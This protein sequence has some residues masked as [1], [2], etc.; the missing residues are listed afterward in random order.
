MKWTHQLS[1]N[2]KGPQ[3]PLKIPN[4]QIEV[5]SKEALVTQKKYIPK[6]NA[7][8]KCIHFPILLFLPPP[9]IYHSKH[10]GDK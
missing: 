4:I 10:L 9:L 5:G 8:S 2:E 7:L 6:D 1:E 3:G